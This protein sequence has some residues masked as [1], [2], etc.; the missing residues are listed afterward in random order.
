MSEHK[1][2]IVGAGMGGLSSALLLAHQGLDVTVVETSDAPGGKVHS[3][4]V[5][6]VHIDSGP[7]VFTMRWVFDDLFRKVGTSL[8]A[9]MRISPLNVLARHFWPDG[10]RLDLSANA[11]ESES[12]IAAW[13]GADEARRFRD[14]C[15]T[16][17]QLYATLEGPMIRAQRPSMG[18]FMGDLG[19]KGLGVLAQ[20]GP[21]RNLWQQLGHQFTDPRLRQLFARYATYCGSSPWQSPATL[22]LI[23]QVE[24]DGVWSVEGGMVGMAQALARVARRHGAVFRYQSTCQRIEKRHGRVC[25]VHLQSGE[26]LPADR[27]IFNGD[28]AALRQGLLGE[29][30][31]QA[32]P[33]AAPPRSL[34]ALTWSLNAPATGVALDRHNVFFQSTYASEFEDIFERQR[35]PQQA[36]VYVCAQDRPAL[37]PEGAA[38][39]IF[40]LVNA[41][42]CGDG[43][44]IT[45]EALEQCQTHT[46]QHLRQLGLHLQ[47]T[48]D[49][50][51]R[52]TPQDFHRRFPASAGALYGQATHGWTSIFSRP[53][54]ATPLQGLYLA[55]GSVHPGPGVPMAALSGQRAAEAVMASLVSTSTFPM[56][57]TFGGMSTP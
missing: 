50:S 18:G 27:V 48:S 46:F 47:P 54:S 26:F 7:T 49:N 12:A 5:Q 33:Q 44:A 45:E 10:S 36:T 56:G 40:C 17:R 1:V 57:A 55:G 43:N 41:P 6:G 39:R 35:L 38:E 30:A 31:R 9:E 11:Q 23:A 29:E 14:F 21:M 2:V 8:E 51:L 37:R 28:A 42:A 13:S 19:F 34:S 53:G 3:R 16:T 4:E 32:V 20:L 22:M 52:T 24:M 25:G 15:N